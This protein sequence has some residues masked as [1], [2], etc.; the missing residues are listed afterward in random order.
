MALVL[1]TG[2][3]SGFGLATARTFAEAGHAVAI[4][5]RREERLTR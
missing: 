3:S 1:V 4:G 2:A 5:A